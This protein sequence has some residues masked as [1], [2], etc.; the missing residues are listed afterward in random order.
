MAKATRQLAT[1]TIYAT[2]S[3]PSESIGFVPKTTYVLDITH[4]PKKNIV[5]ETY[6]GRRKLKCEY[7]T[8]N[9]FLNNWSILNA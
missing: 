9:G 5:I 7:N 3:G 6:H 1:K 4:K 2:F 8:I